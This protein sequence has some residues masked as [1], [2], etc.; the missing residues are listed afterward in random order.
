MIMYTYDILVS[1]EFIFRNKKQGSWLKIYKIYP[2]IG[3]YTSG[4]RSEGKW[5]DFILSLES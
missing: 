3:Q 2:T 5:A 1:H 4:G